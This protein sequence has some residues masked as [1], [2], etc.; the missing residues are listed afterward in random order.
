MKIPRTVKWT[1]VFDQIKDL[2]AKGR[3]ATHKAPI[4]VMRDVSR[5]KTPGKITRVTLAPMTIEGV[6][7]FDL[8]HGNCFMLV[9]FIKPEYADGNQDSKERLA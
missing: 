3:V 2:D 6:S 8:L 7:I 4:K 9:L 1:N 5:K